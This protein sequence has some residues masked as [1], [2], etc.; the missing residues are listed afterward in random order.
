MYEMLFV[1]FGAILGANA[2]FI[3]LNNLKNL[4]VKK[5]LPVLVV[6]TFSS[7]C[8]GLF[9]SIIEK[10][11]SFLYSYQLI[12]FLSVGFLGSFSTFSSFIYDLFELCLEF[13]FYRGFKLII[14]SYALGISAFAIGF[15]LVIQ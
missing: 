1:S 10:F 7:F 14:N 4:N 2:R 13:K 5:D 15:F 6:N 9:I 11:G 8:L 3:I 12:L